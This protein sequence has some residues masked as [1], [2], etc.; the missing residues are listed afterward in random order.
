MIKVTKNGIEASGP[1]IELSEED[2]EFI[3]EMFED[4]AD[5]EKHPL[6]QQDRYEDA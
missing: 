6:N 5:Y 1:P 3:S 2:L 4:F